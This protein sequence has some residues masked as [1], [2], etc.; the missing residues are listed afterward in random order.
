MDI[1]KIV[2]LGSTG[3]IGRSTLEVVER[4]PDR[5]KVIGLTTN[6]STD[7][8]LKQVRRFKPTY[9]AIANHESY[10]KVKE[11]LSLEGCHVLEGSS[12]LI[13][14]ATLKDA[15]IVVASIV[16]S[17]GLIPTYHAIQSGKTIA[18]ANKEVLVSAGDIFKKIAEDKSVKILPVDSEHSAVF[19]CLQGQNFKSIRRLLLTASGGPFF[20]MKKENLKTVTVDEALCHPNWSMGRKIT[21]DSATLMNK[22]LEIIEAH[23]LF[24]IEHK[25]IEAVI[26]RQS[27]VHSLVEFTDGSIICQMS[28]PDMKGPIAY[29]LS[30][31][32][33]LDNVMKQVDLISIGTLT[34]EK[35]DTQTFPC[36]MLAYVALDTGGSM[37]AVL[38]AANEVAVDMF[39]R[40][41]IGFNQIPVIIDKVMSIHN[42]VHSED[43]DVILE[44]DRWARVKAREVIER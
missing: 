44:I 12:G 13:E 5:F 30:Y 19:Q 7:L 10:I 4:F 8:L 16:G 14:V 17:A 34:F 21:I 18:L 9:V 6:N 25:N 11:I 15:D 2:I 1:K 35:P 29:A 28:N 41:K 27:I 33:R 32:E 26:H 40:K 38:N 43:I 23:H 31:P 24:G 42:P 20:G 3:S 22:G 39:L 36:L 37:P